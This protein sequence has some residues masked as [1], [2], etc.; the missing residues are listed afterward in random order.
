MG[1][2]LIGDIDEKSQIQ[3]LDRTQPGLPMKKG[4]AGTMTHETTSVTAQRPCLPLSNR[5][6]CA[7]CVLNSA[8]AQPCYVISI[9][10]RN[11]VRAREVKSVFAY[12]GHLCID[13]AK[14]K[15]YLRQAIW[16][17]AKP[18]STV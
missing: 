16:S 5:F 1:E 10:G 15:R 12:R 14:I 3:A 6:T 18:T 8:S 2:W 7:R 13:E 4:S 17:F 9:S 11:R